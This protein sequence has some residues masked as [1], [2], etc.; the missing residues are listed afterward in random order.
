MAIEDQVLREAQSYAVKHPRRVISADCE[1][2]PGLYWLYRHAKFV[3]ET[4]AKA[5]RFIHQGVQYSIVWQGL[6]MCVM[7]V[8]TGTILVGAPGGS[9]E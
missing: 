3:R 6:R 2:Y 4:R 9:H 5:K 7:H 1:N 8:R